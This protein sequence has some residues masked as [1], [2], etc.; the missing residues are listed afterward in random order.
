MT[1]QVVRV[2]ETHEDADADAAAESNVVIKLPKSGY[3][4]IID[5]L[6]GELDDA[7]ESDD[8]DYMALDG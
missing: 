3:E 4:E 6:Q 8:D 7:G 5:V 1:T 2:I